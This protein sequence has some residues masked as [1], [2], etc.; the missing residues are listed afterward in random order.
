MSIGSFCG[1]LCGNLCEK[2]A[3]A[4]TC[5][6]S[7]CAQTNVTV[8][9]PDKEDVASKRAPDAMAALVDQQ[10]DL[11]RFAQQY[12]NQ[13]SSAA[14][15][16]AVAVPVL[17]SPKQALDAKV[18]WLAAELKGSNAEDMGSRMEYVLKMSRVNLQKKYDKKTNITDEETQEL[19]VNAEK[20]KK[21]GSL[22][23]HLWSVARK[24]RL[25]TNAMIPEISE[26]AVSHLK[27]STHLYQRSTLLFMI[28]HDSFSEVDI[29]MK[30]IFIETALN[31]PEP[32][33]KSHKTDSWDAKL[34]RGS[35]GEDTDSSNLSAEG[36]NPLGGT[37]PLGTPAQPQ[38]TLG[39]TSSAPAH[40]R[41]LNPP[42]QAESIEDD[43]KADYLFSDAQRDN[44]SRSAASKPPLV[45]SLGATNFA[46]QIDQD[47]MMLYGSSSVTPV[48]GDS[49]LEGA[50]LPS[51]HRLPM[52]VVSPSKVY[53]TSGEDSVTFHNT[54]GSVQSASQQIVV[55]PPG[56]R[57]QLIYQLQGT[58]DQFQGPSHTAASALPLNEG[59]VH[60][61]DESGSTS[62]I[63]RSQPS[64]HTS[65]HR[66]AGPSPQ[67]SPYEGTQ[68]LSFPASAI[69]SELVLSRLGPRKGHTRGGSLSEIL[70]PRRLQP[71]SHGDLSS[72]PNRS[73]R[74]SPKERE[75]PARLANRKRPGIR[76]GGGSSAGHSRGS[77]S[78]DLRTREASASFGKSN[79][80]EDVAHA[81]ASHSADVRAREAAASLGKS[82]SL[83]E[84][85][86]RQKK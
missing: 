12:H 73:E 5:N 23:V 13:Q 65:V 19:K 45:P 61:E 21:Y 53:F 1:N 10:F 6:L 76:I 20:V 72:S 85:V 57:T 69:P 41:R 50:L 84:I 9:Q 4:V 67:P 40:V 43:H 15:S 77:N 38:R 32:L 60:Q 34:R 64:P 59:G 25:M 37:N 39:V 68:M 80:V 17:I 47:S 51:L 7:C 79:S 22:A 46:H 82:S 30:K 36:L 52:H 81:R 66:S 58:Q 28:D 3:D 2:L 31:C 33:R 63:L 27:R 75:T 11:Q 83:D 54:D 16:H 35:S 48:V 44:D 49:G 70:H 24:H 26:K 71:T 86:H 18:Q 55:S 8:G 14:S 62:P 29:A 42:E 74:T 56:S 78:A